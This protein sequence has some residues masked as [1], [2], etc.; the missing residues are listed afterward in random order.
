M[1][2]H[3]QTTA[4]VK[5]AQAAQNA[6]TAIV[7]VQPSTNAAI[8]EAHALTIADADSY[9]A[10]D[11]VL[12][13]IRSA[14]QVAE[15][16][17]LVELTDPIIRP[18]RAA[19]DALYDLRTRLTDRL[20]TPLVTAEVVVKRKM[21]EWQAAEKRREQAEAEAR[22]VEA[23]R[24]AREAEAAGRQ[25]EQANTAAARQ[26]AREEADL[27]A[28][29]AA[30][31]RS[32]RQAPALKGAASKVTFRKVWKVTDMTALIAAVVAGDV[33]EIVLQVNT[34]VVEEY[35]KQD[36]ALVSGWAGVSIQEETVVS[37]R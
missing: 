8:A 24:L 4:D 7:S 25:A 31:V 5:L 23:N 1:S 34:E 11:A 37:G 35:W 12:Y 19:L 2:V 20:L 26:R 22:R 16:K 32:V 27:L 9:H 17:I 14:R 30:E 29:Q 10:A 36:R 3:I 33:P 18:A 28:A 21:A 6:E 15:G 13:R